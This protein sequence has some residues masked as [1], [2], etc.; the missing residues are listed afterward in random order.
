[1]TIPKCPKC[2]MSS[3]SLAEIEPKHSR[4]KMYAV[5]CSSCGA[6]VGIIP[7]A[8]TEE[9]IDNLSKKLGVKLD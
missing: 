7:W 8:N 6:T 3:F 1:M 4:F 2:D 5:C 9:L